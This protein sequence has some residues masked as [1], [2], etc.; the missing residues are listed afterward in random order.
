MSNLTDALF[1]AYRE[2]LITVD[3]MM[4]SIKLLDSFKNKYKNT[5]GAEMKGSVALMADVW[6]TMRR[7]HLPSNWTDIIV[8]VKH[9]NDDMPKVVILMHT[10]DTKG[11]QVF[12][13]DQYPEIPMSILGSIYRHRKST[14]IFQKYE[15]V[16]IRYENDGT[17][18]PIASCNFGK[19]TFFRE[20][21][22][23]EYT[24]E[25][26]NPIKA[27]KLHSIIKKERENEHVKGVGEFCQKLYDSISKYI[28][29][30]DLTELLVYA[31]I[32][33]A[34]RIDGKVSVK[35]SDGRIVDGMVYLGMNASKKGKEDRYYISHTI[36]P[37]L[38]KFI[39][40]NSYQGKKLKG[41]IIRYYDDDIGLTYSIKYK[42]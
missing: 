18:E 38:Y 24:I 13:K 6:L 29:Y 5:N 33:E 39:S 35:T 30:G 22:D 37:I 27:V 12:S 42:T 11:Y 25:G 9:M 16:C 15:D 2:D 32:D 17:G 1:E 41:V 8:T 20:S 26:F 34:G 31:D 28:N 23:S 40:S 21:T 4:E 14:S 7:A 3:F 19:K 36:T 10:S